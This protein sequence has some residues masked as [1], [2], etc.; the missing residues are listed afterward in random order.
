MV[1]IFHD[2][3]S[4]FKV[5]CHNDKQQTRKEE[6]Q[7]VVQS[8]VRPPKIIRNGCGEIRRMSMGEGGEGV[9]QSADS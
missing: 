6:W 3:L 4:H 8:K 2:R 9:G 1:A 7:K 5:L